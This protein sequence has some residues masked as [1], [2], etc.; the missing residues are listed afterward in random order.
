MRPFLA[1]ALLALTGCATTHIEVTTPE[2]LCV[3]AS[4]PKN[5]DATK[6]R[7]AINGHELT[8]DRLQTDASSVVKAQ[9]DFAAKI[10]HAAIAAK[11]LTP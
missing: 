3:R 1:F 8:A 5:M 9:A 2:G 7:L 10:A 4:F 11:T 6:L